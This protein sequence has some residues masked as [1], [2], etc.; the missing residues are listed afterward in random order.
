VPR[1]QSA[2]G[3]ASV[4]ALA[5]VPFVLLSALV[6]W[7]LVLVGHTLWLCAGAARAAAR[8]DLVGLSPGRAARS[9][10]PGSLERGLSVKRLADGGVRVKVRMPILLRR[11]PTHVEVA[12]ASSLGERQ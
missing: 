2:S 1:V 8:A 5:V 9:A 11:W 12:A 3:Q 7:Q 6:A 4:E 10:L